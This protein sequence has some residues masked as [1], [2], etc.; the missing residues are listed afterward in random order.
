MAVALLLAQVPSVA[1]ENLFMAR[2]AVEDRRE[3][4]LA[5]AAS[6][7]LEQVLVRV[8]GNRAVL[9]LPGIAQAVSSARDRLSLYTYTEDDAG[10]AL[11]AEFDGVIVKDLLRAAGAT[12]WGASRPPV[13]VWLVVDQTDGRR[14]ANA[15]DDAKLLAPLRAAFDERGVSMRL[16]LMDLEDSLVLGPNILWQRVVPRIMAASERYGTGH[17][18]VGRHVELTDGRL[19]TDWLYVESSESGQRHTTSSAQ[20]EGRDPVS[21]TR[22]AANLVVDAMAQRYA[23]NL[24]EASRQARLTVAVEGVYSFRDYQHVVAL[25]KEITLLDD[26]RV[27]GIDGQRLRLN[28]SGLASGDELQ[29]LIGPRSGL[30]ILAINDDSDLSLLWEDGKP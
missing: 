22:E 19:L 11:I 28:V 13:L 23:I 9:A 1:Q 25:L 15:L 18:L 29:R 7:A 24:N 17:V 12:Y 6:E 8:S 5:R 26:V 3:T 4:S 10:L 30:S 14:F 2:I 20:T 27:M 21:I 16:P